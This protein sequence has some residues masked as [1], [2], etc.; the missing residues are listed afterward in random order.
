MDTIEQAYRK[1]GET[2]RWE[3]RVAM[4]REV[5]PADEDMVWFEEEQAAARAL[6][7]AT[8]R[9]CDDKVGLEDFDALAALRARIERLG[10]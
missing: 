8:L 5:E 10:G 7:L 4:S 1:L 3:G 6:A 2:L 9:E